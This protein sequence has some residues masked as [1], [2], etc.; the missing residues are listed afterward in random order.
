MAS[1]KLLT[2]LPLA[3]VSLTVA[4]LGLGFYDSHSSPE[5]EDIHESFDAKHYD[6]VTEMVTQMYAGRGAYHKHCQLADFVTFEDPAAVCKSPDEVREA[7]R[8]LKK[9]EPRSLSSPKCI[10]VEPRGSSIALTYALHQRY[11]L[12][13]ADLRS[14][15]VVDV[16]LMQIRGLPESEFLITK[17]EERWNGVPLQDNILLWATRRINGI[18]SW[19]LTTRFVPDN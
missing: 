19:H 13:S 7:F 8:V 11:G 12:L 14:N 2:G 16:E 10:N 3:H 5:P 4:S 18:L 1:R 9:L 17:F 6:L 15:L